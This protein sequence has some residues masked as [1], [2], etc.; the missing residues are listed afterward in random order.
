MTA[1][2]HLLAHNRL[3]IGGLYHQ[4]FSADGVPHQLDVLIGKL[5]HTVR[6]PLLLFNAQHDIWTDEN[7]PASTRIFTIRE[8]TPGE[9]L[10]Q[11]RIQTEPA[12]RSRGYGEGLFRFGHMF[13][14]E[15]ADLELLRGKSVVLEETDDSQGWASKLAID[16]G[17]DPAGVNQEG[18]PIFRFKFQ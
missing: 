9:V 8:A 16:M 3:E 10:V 11:S 15:L 13:V 1:G 12:F 7:D 18:K 4:V 14:S 6:R 5:P 2:V 17:Y